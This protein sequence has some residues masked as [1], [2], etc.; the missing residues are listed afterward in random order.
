MISPIVST[1]VF[2][3]LSG[4]FLLTLI[5]L[6]TG[7]TLSDRVIALDLLGVVIVGIIAANMLK[8]GETFYLDVL[9]VFGILIFF[10]T[11]AFARYIEKRF[12]D[13]D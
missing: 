6:L 1:I 11:V 7:P 13:D 3:L 12:Q 2:L 10:G 9:V 4:A 8:S 5:R